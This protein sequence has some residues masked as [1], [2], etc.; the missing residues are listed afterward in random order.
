MFGND[1]M[2]DAYAAATSAVFDL[3]GVTFMDSTG[4]GFLI[5]RYKKCARYSMPMYISAVSAQADRILSMSGVYGLIPKVE[6]RSV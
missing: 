6:R 1:E 3:R 4:I 2:I 5:G